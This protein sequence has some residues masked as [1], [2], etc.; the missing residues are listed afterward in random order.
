MKSH[1]EVNI[2]TFK[3]LKEIKG[4]WT[5]EHFLK[6]M[7]D[8]EYSDTDG[9]SES[10]LKETAIMLLQDLEPEDAALVL[11]KL[12]LGEKL[13]EGQLKNISNEMLDEKLW[14]EYAEPSLHEDF[15]VVASLLYQVAPKIFPKPDAVEMSFDITASND[16]S[17]QDL[18]SHC[19]E[20]FVLKILADGMDNGSIIHRLYGD[21]LATFSIEEAS[22]I[23]WT[24]EKTDQSEKTVSFKLIS[25]GYWMDPLMGINS[26]E[27][28]L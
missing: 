27:S 12:K 16:K 25:S 3:N 6:I 10:D 26:F 7:E 28:S 13:K 15:F 1:F 22:K 5:N 21:Q 23:L 19:Q 2:K 8:L 17:A 14:E 11:L 24:L 4:S 9:M 18:L 20:N